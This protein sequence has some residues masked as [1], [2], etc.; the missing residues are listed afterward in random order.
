[1]A[2]VIN[3]EGFDAGARKSWNLQRE[4]SIEKRAGPD[5]QLWHDGQVH[6]ETLLSCF[7]YGLATDT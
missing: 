2:T 1:M 6:S 5:V 7:H 3:R 4:S